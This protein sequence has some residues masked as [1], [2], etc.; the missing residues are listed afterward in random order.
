MLYKIFSPTFWAH[1]T[2]LVIFGLILLLFFHVIDQAFRS[3]QVSVAEWLAQQFKDMQVAGCRIFHV[4]PILYVYLY[5]SLLVLLL[6]VMA[7]G[8]SC[9]F[10]LQNYWP[11]LLVVDSNPA[12]GSCSCT[13]ILSTQIRRNY[14]T[15]LPYHSDAKLPHH[16]KKCCNIKIRL[17][18]T[19][20]CRL[21]H[22]LS[23][24]PNY[25]V[26]I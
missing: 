22:K 14:P 5:N 4:T 13:F 25:T 21:A 1:E 9:L 15:P 3:Q 23:M 10:L 2:T 12:N 26:L 19:L 20:F 18:K 17:V 8:L 24:Y 6:Y 11:M 16:G 7:C